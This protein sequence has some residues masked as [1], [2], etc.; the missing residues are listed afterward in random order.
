MYRVLL[1][2]YMYMYYFMSGVGFEVGGNS[3]INYLVL[4][5]HYASVD[6]FQGKI[7]RRY[8]PGAWII[9]VLICRNNVLYRSAATE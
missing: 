8:F 5:V 2:I 3:G 1:F 9:L 7:Q 6:S 4:Q